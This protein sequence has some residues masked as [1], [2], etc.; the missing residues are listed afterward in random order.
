M[1]FILFGCQL[2]NAGMFIIRLGSAIGCIACIT[3][4]VGVIKN[5]NN[6]L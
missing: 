1:A 6:F 4:L 3:G 2:K 5:W